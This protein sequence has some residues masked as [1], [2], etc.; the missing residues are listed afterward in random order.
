MRS[1]VNGDVKKSTLSF[2]V[3]M[4]VARVWMALMTEG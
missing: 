2:E 4:N 1:D 3:L